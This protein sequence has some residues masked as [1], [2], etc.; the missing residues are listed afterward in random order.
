[1]LIIGGGRFAKI[2]IRKSLYFATIQIKLNPCDKGDIK[3]IGREI[4]FSGSCISIKVE[5]NFI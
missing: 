4:K 1:M 2:R 3:C 5:Q